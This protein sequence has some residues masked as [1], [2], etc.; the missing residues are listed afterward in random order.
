MS[1]LPYQLEEVPCDSCGRTESRQVIIRPDGMCVVE[2]TT[3]GLAYLN[4]RPKADQ[5]RLF[6]DDAYFGSGAKKAGVGYQTYSH[7]SLS[8]VHKAT[9]MNKLDVIGSRIELE[10][11][12]ALEIGCATGEFCQVLYKRGCSV[13]G[14]DLSKEVIELAKAR[15]PH[16]DLRPGDLQSAVR[17][18]KFD[19]IFAWE[20]V[21]H[22]T[23]PEGFV[24]EISQRLSPNGYV[25]LST[26][27]YACAKHVQPSRWAGFQYS[28]EHLY[29]FDRRALENIGSHHG[30]RHVIS[31]SGGGAGLVPA[32]Q[33]F[34]SFVR[35]VLSST[36]TL[37][38]V[39]QLR[40]AA[41]PPG[42]GYSAGRE[43]QHNLIIILQHDSGR[44]ARN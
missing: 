43:D 15:Y 39:R 28:F 34:R 2:C 9:G 25:V 32:P 26:P 3:C 7:E 20:V 31:Y 5:I 40:A 24:A 13:V 16:L 30:L 10:G 33:R 29:F 14:V 19:V 1:W 22:V 36:G 17:D 44:V 37:R 27:N 6:Y 42:I 41:N 21:E 38:A 18:D 4:P 12:R 23:S 11:K 35:K 8:A